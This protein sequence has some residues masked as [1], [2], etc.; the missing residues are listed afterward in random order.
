MNAIVAVASLLLMISFRLIHQTLNLNLGHLTVGPVDLTSPPYV[1]SITARM[2]EKKYIILVPS[3]YVGSDLIL[4][5][6]T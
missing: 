5:C 2:S 6:K 3:I 1:S 4:K